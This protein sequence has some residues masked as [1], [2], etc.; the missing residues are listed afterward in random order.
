MSCILYLY[1]QKKGWEAQRAAVERSSQEARERLSEEM[2][3]KAELSRQLEIEKEKRAQAEEKAEELAA[4]MRARQPDKINRPETITSIILAP[5][6]LERG[7]N[8]KVL[9]LKAETGRVQLQLELDEGQR[10]SQYSVLLTTFDGRRVWSRNSVAASQIKQGRLNLVLPA[11]LLEYEDYKIE[12]KGL[13]E[14]GDF[15]HVADYLF[16]ARR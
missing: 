14:N 7:G 9:S 11:S 5:T 1:S 12:L 15:V 3:G 6:T 13:S 10:Y 16:K 8:S 4:Q 2:Q